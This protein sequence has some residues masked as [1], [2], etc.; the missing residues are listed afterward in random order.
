[1][2]TT[3]ERAR[4]YFV[5]EGRE[6]SD[7]DLNVLTALLEA[8]ERE[9]RAE[10]ADLCKSIAARHMATV[11]R[12]RA[13]YQ[14]FA[15]QASGAT[16]CEMAILALAPARE[17]GVMVHDCIGCGTEDEKSRCVRDGCADCCFCQRHIRPGSL[18][19]TPAISHNPVVRDLLDANVTA[20]DIAKAITKAE[21]ESPFRERPYRSPVWAEDEEREKRAEARTIAAVVA[22]LSEPWWEDAETDSILRALK[23][24]DWRAYLPKGGE[25][26]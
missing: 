2:T 15:E 13:G 5:A 22:M 19:T 4:A 11:K 8:V 6:P 9:T 24:N 10:D 20:D 17:G 18:W 7:G 3:R 1:M 23:G 21:E 26:E 16:Q 12:S 14:P 25:G